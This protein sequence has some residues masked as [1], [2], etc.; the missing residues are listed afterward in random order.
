MGRNQPLVAIVT[1]CLLLALFGAGCGDPS[2]FVSVDG[3]PAEVAALRVRTILNGQTA[4]DN[5]TL[6]QGTTQ[7]IV[8]LPTGASGQVHL[9]IEG[10]DGQGCVLAQGSTDDAVPTG[11]RRYIE[12]TVTLMAVSTTSCTPA[13]VSKKMVCSPDS[14]C[15]YVHNR[16]EGLCS[17]SGAARATTSGPLET[18]GR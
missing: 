14:W 4:P 8:R 16:R 6:S 2:L 3:I 10:V 1:A 9:D 13:S 18:T 15:W 7:F 17:E 5:Q 11:L 12:R